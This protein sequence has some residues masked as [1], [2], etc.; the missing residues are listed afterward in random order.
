MA[1][2]LTFHVAADGNDDWSG[3]LPGQDAGGRDGPFRSLERARAAVGAIPHDQPIEVVLGEGPF[4]LTE[5]L[6]FGPDDGGTAGCPVTWRG[7]TG[8]TPVITG[9]QPLCGEWQHHNG[10]IWKLHLPEVAAGQ[11]C[12]RQLFVNGRRLERTRIPKDGYFTIYGIPGS[13]DEDRRSRFQYLQGD[14]RRWQHLD[15]VEFVVL[16]SWSESRLFVKELDEDDRTVSFTGMAAYPFDFSGRN[17]YY[18][19][20]VLEALAE[21]GQ[22]YLERDTGLL[23]VIPP[24]GVDLATAR[25]EIALPK[26]L[27]HVRG[28]PENQVTHLRFEGLAFSGTR[29]AVP[30]TGY[31][32]GG[33]ATG[34]HVRP[35]AITFEHARDCAIHQCAVEN[36]A[37]YGIELADCAVCTVERSEIREAGGG[38]G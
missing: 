4:R 3:R 35:A 31:A 9:L 18:V 19:E 27:L 1:E 36:T 15:D 28:T 10:P 8:K 34:P 37:T 24:D 25:V 23:Y 17:T 7:Q 11:C 30:D 6:V 22:W 38:L 14:V 5:P 29:W 21:P 20:N 12:F 33:G 13:S 2:K 32:N 16:H 26:A